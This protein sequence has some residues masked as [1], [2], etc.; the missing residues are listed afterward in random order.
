MTPV[1]LMAVDQ[2]G[3]AMIVTLIGA[4]AIATRRFPAE[5]AAAKV[6]VTALVLLVTLDLL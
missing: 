2:P 1:S 4:P 3:G 6:A 5:G